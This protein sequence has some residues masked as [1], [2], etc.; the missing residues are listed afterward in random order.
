MLDLLPK[1]SHRWHL[2]VML[3]RRD[4]QA[5]YVQ[6]RLGFLWVLLNPLFLVVL[7]S[8]VFSTVM[9]VRTQAQDAHYSYAVFLMSGMVAYL[10]LQEAVMSA[11]ACLN[12][13]KTLLIKSVF[14]ADILPIN[15]V[16]LSVVGELATVLVL[17]AWVGYES[18]QAYW[19][20]LCLPVLMA[21]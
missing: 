18:R 13:K 21:A 16:L 9:S 3:W 10:A 5:S 15:S 6:N 14:P 19:S 20:W 12:E 2:L 11:L 8:Y 7:Y 17:L 4:V 1:L